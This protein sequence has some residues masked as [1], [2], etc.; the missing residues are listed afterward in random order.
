M[1]VQSYRQPI[2]LGQA[3]PRNTTGQLLQGSLNFD[4]TIEIVRRITHLIRFNGSGQEVSSGLVRRHP[5]QHNP[6]ELLGLLSG[7]FH[8]Q[9]SSSKNWDSPAGDS[10]YSLV[11]S[12]LTGKERSATPC[13]HMLRQ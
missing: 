1:L 11:R 13:T 6:S 12:A 2:F 8:R 5:A 10:T 3:L 9:I 4:L 7:Q